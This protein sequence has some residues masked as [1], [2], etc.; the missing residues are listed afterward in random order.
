MQNGVRKGGKQTSQQ[1]RGIN[2]YNFYGR[3]LCDVGLEKS[4][5]P[6]TDDNAPQSPTVESLT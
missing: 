1:R 3:L 5:G 6:T 4:V 2:F